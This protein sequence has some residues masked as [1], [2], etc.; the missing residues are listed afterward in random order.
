MIGIYK[1]LL[2]QDPSN[3]A[4]ELELAYIYHE[5]G[6]RKESLAMLRRLGQQSLDDTQVLQAVADR[7]LETKRYDAASVVLAGLLSG[8]PESSDL[9]Y[10]A[11]VAAN[12]QSKKAEAIDHFTRVAPESRFYQNATVHLAFL[13]REQGNLNKGISILTTLIRNVPDNV[14]IMLYLGSFYEEAKNYP[15]AVEIL[16]RAKAIAPDSTDVLFRL[17][18]V[19]DKWGRKPE[20]IAAMKQVIALEPKN[21]NALNYLGYTYADMGIHL[22]EALSLVQRALESKPDDGYILDSLGWV[23]YK[24]GLYEKSLQYMEKASALIADDPTILEHLGDVYLKLNQ[25]KEALKAYRKSLK[26]KS[27]DEKKLKEKILRL[28]KEGDVP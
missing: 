18:V 4:N 27:L 5:S 8:A 28:E 2:D 1:D 26:N 9:Q 24:K 6:H 15:K 10:L 16:Q 12:A 7:F 17:G 14:D 22:D 23:Y 11:G 19:Y 20:S 21:A 13:Y 25:R 3:V